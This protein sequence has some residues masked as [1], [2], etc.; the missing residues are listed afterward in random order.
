MAQP[1][2]RQDRSRRVVTVRLFSSIVPSDCRMP[3]V[4]Q[5]S[6]YSVQAA[7]PPA[8]CVPPRLA[9]GAEQMA[10]KTATLGGIPEPR[11]SK[12]LVK[13]LGPVAAG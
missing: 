5:G 2:S 4:D 11:P 13:M 10:P 1:L 12:R 7:P 9:S 6:S 8:R 3:Y